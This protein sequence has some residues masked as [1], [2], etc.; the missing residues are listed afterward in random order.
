MSARKHNGKGPY[1]KRI[2]WLL[3]K[4]QLDLIDF[5]ND[6][7]ILFVKDRGFRNYVYQT[8]KP[9]KQITWFN[10]P[11]VWGNAI[12][13]D[14]YDTIESE[15]MDWYLS[16]TNQI[17]HFA[18]DDEDDLF[19][20]DNASTSTESS[21]TT[22]K[23]ESTTTSTKG[24]S[25]SQVSTPGAV[26]KSFKSKKNKAVDQGRKSNSKK[27]KSSK[28][29]ASTTTNVA[30]KIKGTASEGKRVATQSNPTGVPEVDQGGNAQQLQTSSGNAHNERG[31]VQ[32]EAGNLKIQKPLERFGII[33]VNLTK[34]NR[35]VSSKVYIFV[36]KDKELANDLVE[37]MEEAYDSGDI[38]IHEIKN[39]D[40]YL[41][42]YKYII[43]W[44][45]P[46]NISYPTLA[47]KLGS[48]YNHVK[49]FT[50]NFDVFSDDCKELLEKSVCVRFKN[51][52]Q[53]YS[54]SEAVDKAQQDALK[55]Q[56]IPD[57]KKRKL[58]SRFD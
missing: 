35:Y 4:Y 58:C 11:F 9:F 10:K 42:G 39:N 14:F 22:E 46:F 23:S 40:E 44:K 48:R 27:A 51:D 49:T 38:I 57:T 28:G 30:T 31:T 24:I 55:Y 16:L 25:A 36:T 1:Y 8:F 41:D 26:P 2:N 50:K 7:S 29:G 43:A 17:E 34:M 19:N 5:K 13:Q 45:L 15:N 3:D 56:T 21:T 33:K 54:L 37:I 52:V 12:P 53:I 20:I 47:L 6:P 18:D 32:G